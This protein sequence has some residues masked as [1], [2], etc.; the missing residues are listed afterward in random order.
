MPFISLAG[1]KA[2][3]QRL[4]NSPP[5]LTSTSMHVEHHAQHAKVIGLEAKNRV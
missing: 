4:N 1:R 3:A 2:R 5:E